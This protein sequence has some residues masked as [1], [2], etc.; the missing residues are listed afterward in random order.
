MQF[1]AID[2]FCG[3]GGL[4]CG[5]QQ[6]DSATIKVLAGLDVDRYC[7]DVYE[8]NNGAKFICG[9][10][11]NFDFR[12]LERLYSKN[13]VRILVGCAPCQPF[14][15]HSSKFKNKAQDKRWGLLRYFAD[16]VKII[17][18]TL[19]SMENV[20]GLIR[21]D[22]FREFKESLRTMGYQVNVQIANCADYGVPQSR[23]RLVLLGSKWGKIALAKGES[24]KVTVAD[25]IR[26]LP[27]IRAGEACPQERFH[28]AQNLMPINR[29]RIQA[30]KPGGD[31]NDWD[32][33]LLPNCCKT[34]RSKPYR[35]VYGRMR[36]DEVAPTITTQFY[37][38][39][40]GRFGH[41]TQH[42]ALSLREG[43]LLQTF[44]QEYDFGEMSLGRAGRYIGNAVPPNLGYAIGEAIVN[45]AMRNH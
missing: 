26:H 33:D 34:K 36:W 17:Q 25:A 42:R 18:P 38:Y 10:V 24:D 5:L 21:T 37:Y 4:T 8:Q 20:P 30:S 41:P 19:V 1:E 9:D 32:P 39:G 23:K 15:S 29:R 35:A 12:K 13:S 6:V 22:V 14:S 27:E 11:S 28:R 44:P 2:L 43:A 31:W 40:A 45:H 16:A 7:K 3:A